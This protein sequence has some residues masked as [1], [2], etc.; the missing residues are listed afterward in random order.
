VAVFESKKSQENIC[1]G[2]LP[3]SE[4]NNLVARNKKRAQTIQIFC[5][6][7][8]AVTILLYLAF[9]I[10]F[11]ELLEKGHVFKWY[12]VTQVSGIYQ[13]ALDW[14]LWGLIGT[15]IYLLTEITF[16]YRVIE[17]NAPKNNSFLAFTPWYISTLLKSPFTVLV[18][19]LFFNA[20]NLNLTG[21]DSDN[22]A[23]AFEFSKLDHRVTVAIAFVLG[24]YSRVGRSVL[25]GMVKSLF[26]KAWAEAH[27]TFEINP[28]DAK[29]VLGESAIFDT[30]PKTD[31]VWATSL[32]SIDSIGRFTAPINIEDCNKTA[33]ITA[34]STGTQS[35]AKSAV[36]EILPFKIEIEPSVASLE[37]GK[38]YTFLGPAELSLQWEATNGNMNPKTGKFSADPDKTVQEVTITATVS[39]GDLK[40][41]YSRLSMKYLK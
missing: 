8:L 30:S 20:A 15:F 12:G 41:K 3:M 1:T 18:I 32:G 19:M 13:R 34:V 6:V 40:G 9:H 26:P 33:V 28:K 23:I 4:N 24:F 36:V 5:I 14:T 38:E 11:F 21:T 39:K 35:I 22:P 27:E 2:G 7:G 37:H 29:I 31:V 25:D 17:E 10:W 16:H